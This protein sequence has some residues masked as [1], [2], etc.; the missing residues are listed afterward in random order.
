MPVL[1]NR[2]SRVETARTLP[3][4]RV[5]G[6]YETPLAVRSGANSRQIAQASFEAGVIIDGDVGVAVQQFDQRLDQLASGEMSSNVLQ[7]SASVAIGPGIGTVLAD[8]TGG[9]ITITLPLAVNSADRQISV[10]KTDASG[11]AVTLDGN[12]AETIDGAAGY[13][14]PAQN[15]FVTVLCDG[16]NWQVI[17]MG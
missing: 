16:I 2:R 1:G 4:N 17:G 6:A 15:N 7:A 8:A 9:A 12:G 3:G 14:L 10:K 5:P 11:N 13:A